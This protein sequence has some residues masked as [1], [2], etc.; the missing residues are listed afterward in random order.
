MKR[1]L[2]RSSGVPC[3]SLGNHARGTEMVRP[4]L[5]STAS[6]SAVTLTFCAFAS[7]VKE[8]IPTP[9]QIFPILLNHS[10]YAVDLSPAEAAAVLQPHGVKPELGLVVVPFDV[11]VWRL[12][13]VTSIK[14][15]PVRP[16]PQNSRHRITPS[17]Q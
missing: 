17:R 13:R 16:K 12:V 2:F 6:V 14:E 10:L 5:K 11:D 8:L 3:R 9:Q 7:A 4:S 1:Q 15:E